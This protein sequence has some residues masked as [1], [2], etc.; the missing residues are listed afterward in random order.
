MKIWNYIGEFLLFRW[1]FGNRG[2]NHSAGSSYTA[3]TNSYSDLHYAEDDDFSSIGHQ[4]ASEPL[5]HG[6]DIYDDEDD[7]LDD[8]DP[9]DSDDYQ[10]NRYTKYDHR[11][12]G[13]SQSHDELHEEQDDYDMMDDDF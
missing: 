1:L 10:S 4:N 8:F 5:Y 12:Y 13:Y 7:A 3:N 2:R 11:D 6:A 9:T